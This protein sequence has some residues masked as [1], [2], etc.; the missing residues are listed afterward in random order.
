MTIDQDQ[1]SQILVDLANLSGNDHARLREFR[2]RHDLGSD[3]LPQAFSYQQRRKFGR[4]PDA[5]TLFFRDLAQ[6]L[7]SGGDQGGIELL[8]ALLFTEGK[9][10][11][12]IDWWH[13]R[14]TYKPKTKLQ[15]AFYVLLLNNHLTKRCAKSGCE[16]PF[17]IGTRVDERYCS[18]KCKE[19]GRLAT[20]REWW[21]A[22]RARRK[23]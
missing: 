11:I 5:I 23:L 22:N 17:F 18:D 4:N 3:F 1:S 6:R 13:Q 20:K 16:R 7:W 12:E 2:K 8:S 15:A 19:I 21:N 9:G 14:L 10:D